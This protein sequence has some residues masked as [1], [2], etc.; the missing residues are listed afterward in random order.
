VALVRQHLLM[1][2]EQLEPGSEVI[3]L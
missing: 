3:I 2:L 1:V